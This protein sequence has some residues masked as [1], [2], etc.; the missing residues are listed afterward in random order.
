M[1][2]SLTRGVTPRYV[3]D[4]AVEVMPDAAVVTNDQGEI[5]HVI[6]HAQDMF[7]YPTA[8]LMGEYIELLILDSGR[9]R[10]R[11]RRHLDLTQPALPEPVGR[12]RDGSRFPIEIGFQTI[13]T[14]NGA[15]TLTTFRDI[16]ERRQI[17]TVKTEFIQNAAHELRT[18]LAAVA[19]LVQV[20]T[21]HRRRMSDEQLEDTLGAL[22]RQGERARVLVNNLLDLTQLEHGRL[23]LNIERTSLRSAIDPALESHPPP[24]NI[25]LEFHMPE[26]AWV[27]VDARRFVQVMENL[28][29][30]AY[31]SGATKVRVECA[32]M[33]KQVLIRVE[34]DGRGVSEE[35]RPSL[36]E[37]FSRGLNRGPEGSGLGLA[38][39]RSLIEA[40]GGDMWFEPVEPHGARFNLR[41]PRVD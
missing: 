23:D 19:G 12:R 21:Q 25:D 6:Q 38:L 22:Q 30:N 20:L 41:I 40:F 37:P 3:L 9:R 15:L 31:R 10:P 36:F 16:T 26:E 27:M 8:E 1:R 7:G 32:S 33:R 4:L 39:G 29:S 24:P 14:E 11:G 2:V 18:P 35:L 28:L 5:V 17:E 34:D 13:E